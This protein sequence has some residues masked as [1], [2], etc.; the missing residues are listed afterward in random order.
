MF[1][2]FFVVLI[3]QSSD[4]VIAIFVI[5]LVIRYLKLLSN[6]FNYIHFNSFPVAPIL[7][8]PLLYTNITCDPQ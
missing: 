7:V 8:C 5:I 3:S 4:S 2:H 6:C 1:E